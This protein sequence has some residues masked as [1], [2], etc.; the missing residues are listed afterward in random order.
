MYVYILWNQYGICWK[1]YV[2][3][4]SETKTKQDGNT[5]QRI[6]DNDYNKIIFYDL[7]KAEMRTYI[8]QWD[9]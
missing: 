8:F 1:C 7:M 2:C 5:V 3:L 9:W 4:T 6:Y